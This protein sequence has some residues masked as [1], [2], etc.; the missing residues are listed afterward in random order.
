MTRAYAC[1]PMGNG[2]DLSEE[3]RGA[4]VE[5][6]RAHPTTLIFLALDRERPVGII[7]C[8]VGFSTFA[9][10]PLVNIHDLH[11]VNEYRRSG[12]ARLL[13]QAVEEKARE[14]GCCKLTLEVQENNH[15]ALALYSNFGFVDGQYEPDAGTVLFR[16]K[17][18]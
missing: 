16:V 11:V 1:D 5:G 3:V 8:F 13:L 4:L 6:L 14:H 18:L 9:A 12:V 10:R 15:T 7:T 17:K 2:R